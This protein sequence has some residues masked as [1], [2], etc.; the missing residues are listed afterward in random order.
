MIADGVAHR[1]LLRPTLRATYRDA[2]VDSPL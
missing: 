2:A 1:R